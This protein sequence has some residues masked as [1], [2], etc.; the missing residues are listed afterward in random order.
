MIRITDITLCT[1]KHWHVQQDSLVKLYCLLLQTGINYIEITIPLINILGDFVDYKRTNLRVSNPLEIEDYPGFARYVCRHSGYSVPDG[2]ISE[3]QIN[4]IR[5][6]NALGKCPEYQNIR[7]VGMDD[8]LQHDFTGVFER[9]KRISDAQPEFCPQNNQYCATALAVEWVLN[10]G[11][12][13]VVSFGGSGGFAA[14]EEVVMALRIVKRHKPNL[15]LSVF[16]EIKDLYE[17]LSGFSIPDTKPVIGNKI[18]D[19]ESGIH[20]DGIFKNGATYEPFEPSIVG[21]ERKIVLGKHS[22]RTAIEIKLSEY[23]IGFPQDRIGELLKKVQQMSI[24]L[25]R[26]IADQEFIKLAINLA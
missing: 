9:L 20:V 10:G 11:E 26:S 19:V 16:R 6:I 14:L 13:I 7:I 15:D 25:G 2:T 23:D 1:I 17:R 22:G 3:F 5:E 21:M 8:I 4:D 12:N 18:F 24:D